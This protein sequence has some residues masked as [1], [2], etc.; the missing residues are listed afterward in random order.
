MS[1]KDYDEIYEDGKPWNCTFCSIH[2]RVLPCRTFLRYGSCKC[3]EYSLIKQTSE[4]CPYCLG[5]NKPGI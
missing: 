3:S 4:F 5:E 2:N 1:V